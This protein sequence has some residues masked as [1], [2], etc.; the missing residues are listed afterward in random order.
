MKYLVYA[1]VSPRGNTEKETSIAMQ[2]DMCKHYIKEQGGEIVDVVFD[3][4]YSGK[5]TERPG[6]REILASLKNGQAQWDTIVVYKLSRLTRS[7]RDGSQIFDELFKWGKGFVSIT[8]KNLDFSTPSGRAMLGILHVFN[9]FEREQTAENTRN[10]M[11][12]IAKKGLWPSGRAPYGYKRGAKGDNKLYIDERKS[13]KLKNMFEMYVDKKY[14]TVDIVKKHGISKQQLLTILRSKTSLGYIVYG[15]GEYSGQHEAILDQELFNRA[16]QILPTRTN[17]HIRV[18]SQKYD[19]ILAG[20]IKCHCGRHMTPES[21]KSGQYFYY[22]C[23]DTINCKS[24][25]NALK[26]EEKALEKLQALNI[27]P[28][29]LEVALIEIEQRRIEEGKSQLPKL[30]TAQTALRK[31]K[32]EQEKVYNLMIAD[33]VAYKNLDFFNKRLEKVN[34]EI[35]DLEAEIEFL[36]SLQNNKLD[37]YG[38]ASKM[39]Q[40]INYINDIFK[41][42]PKDKIVQ[43][44]LITTHIKEITAIKNGT[45]KFEFNFKSSTKWQEWGG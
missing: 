25:V 20:I 38:L 12:S 42:L 28:K 32:Q 21:A 23:T 36:N 43:R 3:E 31:A 35:T 24:R 5:N 2:I 39:V 41:K 22:R 18:K 13:L 10:K 11:I 1:R 34:D 30:Y 29:V 27:D 6:M 44:Q 33:N 16:Q 15:G 8:E 7:L 4:F 17:G 19:Y 14:M 40:E 45:F 37:V 26:V 9:Q